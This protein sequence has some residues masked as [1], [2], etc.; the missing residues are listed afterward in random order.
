MAQVI[1]S[2]PST[3]NALL[4]GTPHPNTQAFLHQQVETFSQSLTDA[5][6]RFME[7]GR[8]IY[9]Y[10]SGSTAMR[11]ARAAKKA[12][13]S[14]WQSNEIKEL[15]ELND[16]Q[17]A[18][19]NMQRWIMAN[20]TVRKLYHQQ[21][22][23]GYAESYQDPFPNDIGEEHYDYRRVMNGIVVDNE[24]GDGWSATTWYEDLLPDDR[25]LEFDEQLDI[26]YS[27]ENVVAL[28]R[29]GGEDPTSRFGAD[30]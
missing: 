24:N 17:T 29:K 28:I 25:E 15:V 10:L 20:T 5:G 16:F 12:M 7:E 2:D 6:R 21:R 9:D 27:W 23:E 26:I 30:L 22:V 1:V 4:Y 19:L 11:V 14:I 8:Q 13:G 3:F 18:H